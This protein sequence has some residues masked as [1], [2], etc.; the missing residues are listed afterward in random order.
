MSALELL[1]LTEAGITGLPA[2][3][4]SGL[5]A[6]EVLHL[7]SN[8]PGSLDAGLFSGLTELK[9][10]D[11]SHSEITSVPS[12][13]FSGLTVLEVLDLGYNKLSSVDANLLS[14]PT[15]LTVFSLSGNDLTGLPA[16]LFSGQTELRWLY[17]RENQFSALPDGLFSGLT[18]LTRLRLEDNTVDP[19]PVDVSLEGVGSL[20]RAKA[21]TAAPFELVL[22]LRLANGEIDSGEESIAVPQ[23]S[24]QSGFL[25]V[26]RTAGTSAAVTVDLGALPG[27]PASD[28]GYVFVRSGDLPVEVIAAEEGVEIYP[29]ELTMPEDGSD[30]YTVVLTS[31]PTANVT[32]TVTVPAGADLSVDPSPLTFTE[33]NWPTPQ[34]VMVSAS[35]D[36]D[37]EDDEV[38]LSHT[39]SGG[40][41]QGMTVDNVEVKITETDVT[42]NSRP[43]FATT[44]FDVQENQTSGRHAGR[45]RCRRQGLHHRIRDHRRDRSGP[46]RDHQPGRV[47]LRGTARLRTSR[48]QEQPV[49]W[50]MSPPPAAWAP[51]NGPVSSKS[52]SR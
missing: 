41:Y 23:G 9:G 29:T 43:V 46:V 2:T 52:S 33:D 18:A 39:V 4:F 13:L 3:V 38:A 34:T 10:I 47:E 32:V 37:T 14:A 1:D 12:N 20:F 5:S 49:S 27:L 50:S 25:S 28:S 21:H 15:A 40:G 26:S 17:L 16:T 35:A 7:D 11:L 24:I 42:A 8:E 19:L 6:L 31:R 30:S 36:A 48:R 45:H 22:P 51:G 44:S